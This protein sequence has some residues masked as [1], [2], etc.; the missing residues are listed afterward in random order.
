MERRRKPRRV[1]NLAEVAGCR[2]ADL[3]REDSVGQERERLP[4]L[5][6]QRML[7]ELERELAR[8]DD[9]EVE[10]AA[11]EPREAA[12]QVGAQQRLA[13]EDRQGAERVAGALRREA[14]D[15]ERLERILAAGVER[16]SGHVSL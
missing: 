12:A 1:C 8:G 4:S 13:D 7:A 11:G 5:R 15:K 2:R 16:D 9:S 10:V 3:L 6:H 14:L